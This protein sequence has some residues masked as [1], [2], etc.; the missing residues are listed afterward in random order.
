MP[1]K[2]TIRALFA[3]LVTLAAPLAAYAEDAYQDQEEILAAAREFLATQLA[4]H[5][6]EDADILVEPL[7]PR[8]R[9]TRCEE[10]L[11]AFL[12][13]GG[14]LV[15]N[16]SVGVSCNAPKSWSLYV[17]AKISVF[18]EVL[19]AARNLPRGTHLTGADASF[20]RRDLSRLPYGY[21]T[22]AA[23]L[24]SKMTSRR[25]NAGTVLTPS[26]MKDAPMVKRGERV[27]LSINAS[28]L[29]IRAS[30]TAMQDGTR[31]QHI[32]VRNTSSK[33][34]VEGVILAP[35]LVEVNN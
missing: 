26:S 31:G 7:D 9:L 13:A 25:I 10:P 14:Q 35:G 4:G 18:A 5:H 29:Q 8:L 22:D 34:I 15:G 3:L 17:S 1:A 12:P 19:V 33:R 30:G 6:G 16:T 20:E 23:E 27:T 21:L 28:G 32:R 2:R 11:E 24:E